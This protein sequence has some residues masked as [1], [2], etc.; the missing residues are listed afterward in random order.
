MTQETLEDINEEEAPQAKEMKKRKKM[1]AKIKNY[2]NPT[3]EELIYNY[4]KHF[5]KKSISLFFSKECDNSQASN[6][7]EVMINPDDPS[8]L[9]FRHLLFDVTLKPIKPVF[10]DMFDK[11]SEQTEKKR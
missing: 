6:L 4:P 5:H 3:L 7:W 1:A 2:E 9:L 10:M 8:T 11:D